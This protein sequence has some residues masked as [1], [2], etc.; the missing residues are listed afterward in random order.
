MIV[1]SDTSPIGSLFLIG[2]ID[3]LPAVFGNVIIPEQV[4]AELLVLETD[5]G[6]DLTSLRNAPWLKIRDAHDAQA[7]A[8]L[9]T[10]LDQGESEAIVL[11]KELNADFLL[12]DE[13][14]GRKIAQ[15]EGLQI[16]GLLGVLM[17][18]KRKG[19]IHLV[20]PLLD[21][22]RLRADFRIAE[23]LYQEVLRR[24]GE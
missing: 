22:L 15:Q 6:H 16:I 23:S 17:Q 24:V 2:Q 8:R 1:V 9:R 7:V 11:A 20:K 19:L 14:E 4:F 5:F 21:D 3:L 18:A 13:S 10:I 12:I